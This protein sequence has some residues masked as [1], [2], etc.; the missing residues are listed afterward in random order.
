MKKPY[1]RP[2]L[3]VHGTVGTLTS[4]LGGGTSDGQTGSLPISNG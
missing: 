1:T 2:S 3:V 4:G